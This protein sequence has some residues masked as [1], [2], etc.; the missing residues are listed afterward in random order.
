MAINV[1]TRNAFYAGR[2]MVASLPAHTRNLMLNAANGRIRAGVAADFD[3]TLVPTDEINR[4]FFTLGRFEKNLEALPEFGRS[5]LLLQTPVLNRNVMSGLAMLDIPTGVISGNTSEY[6]S[7]RC[8]DPVRDFIMDS[9]VFRTRVINFATYALNGG[10]LTIFDGSGAE[11][12]SEMD[13]YNATKK[14]PPALATE[15]TRVMDSELPRTISSPLHEPI[16]IR[17]GKTEAII[18]WPF[19]QL[20]TGVQICV[21]G[22]S[23]ETRDRMINAIRSALSSRA[24]SLLNIQ[25]GGQYT[26]DG[27]MKSLQKTDAGIDF[28]NRYGLDHL[29]YLGDAVYKRDD[30]EGNDFSM[31]HNPNTT[32]LAVNDR[33]QDVPDHNHVSWI[34]KGPTASY[35]WLTW[36]LIERANN[37]IEQDPHRE[38]EMWGLFQYLGFCN[39]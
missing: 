38:Q 11:N 35:K 29:F 9:I 2:R 13:V 32:V 39:N 12:L 36:F 15:L 14:I 27:G 17:S 24:A 28:F 22:V 16:R 34:G 19:V 5:Q 3:G 6:V 18:R 26:I 30:K 31:V 37:I 23:G 4:L 21:I 25:P 10:L 20:R 8:T 33:K 7:A 1:Q